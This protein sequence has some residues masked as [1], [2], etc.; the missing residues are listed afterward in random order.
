MLILYFCQYNKLDHFAS[1][2]ARG[3]GD[4]MEIIQMTAV[5][6]NRG[7][8]RVF[9]RCAMAGNELNPRKADCG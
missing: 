7:T 8:D 4:E 6:V 9:T 2:A 5:F 3:E 1:T